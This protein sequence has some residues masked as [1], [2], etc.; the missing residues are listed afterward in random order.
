MK[1]KMKFVIIKLKNKRISSTS[2]FFIINNLIRQ[3]TFCF[4]LATCYFCYKGKY[5]IIKIYY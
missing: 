2:K 3:L 5:F 1:S 4:N